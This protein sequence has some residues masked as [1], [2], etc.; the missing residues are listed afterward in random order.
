MSERAPRPPFL[1]RALLALLIRGEAREFIAG[2]LEEEYVRRV[3]PE[4]G[5]VEARAWFWRQSLGSVASRMFR[6]R[7]PASR[8]PGGRQPTRRPG[9]L[10]EALWQDVRF[11][12]RGLLARPA[13][14][15]TA[16]LT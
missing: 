3:L 5:R 1:A 12:T 8:P 4:R 11:G 7:G 14:T 6:A 15:A 16:V 2:D 13:F 10:L 9:R